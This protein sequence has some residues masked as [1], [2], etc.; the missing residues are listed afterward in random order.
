MLK[1]K[2][3]PLFIVFGIYFALTGKVFSFLIYTLCAL[4]HEMG[5]YSASEKL[6]YKLNKIVLMPYGAIISGNATELS[7]K[8]EI[9]VAL[10]GPLVNLIVALFFIA[11]W[12]LFPAVYPFT[13]EIVIANVSLVLINL[14]PCY[15]LD[16]GRFLLATLSL[17]FKRQTAIKIVKILG[18]ALGVILLALFF[19]SIAVKVNFTILFFSLFILVGSLVGSREGEY[20]KIYQ[21]LTYKRVKEPKTI[22]E[23]VVDGEQKVKSLYPLLNGEYYYTLTVLNG[24][25]ESKISGEELFTMLGL[26][27]PYDTVNFAIKKVHE[28][29]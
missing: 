15:P 12:W 6:G 26:S 17:K 14:L 20:V 24:K 8:D 22:K 28:I 2:L 5:H 27:S 13:E 1:F 9:K 3:H 7:F 29:S 16:G 19:Y 18:V 4:I 10:S 25:S 23:I 21:N 11:T